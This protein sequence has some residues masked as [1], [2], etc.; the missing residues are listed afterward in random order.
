MT[1]FNALVDRYIELWNESDAAVREKAIA[2]MWTE[3]A[4]YVDPLASVSGHDG[5]AAVIAGAREMFPGFVFRALPDVD[6]HHDT[7]RFGWELVPAQGGESIV[8][9]FDVAVV[10]TDGRL[11]AVRGFIDKAP[12]QS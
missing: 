2:E 12:V 8:V 7:V 3:N 6:G 10:A 11:Q 5:I 9:G 4:T 1:D